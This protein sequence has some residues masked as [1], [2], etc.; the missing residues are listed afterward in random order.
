[1]AGSTCVSRFKPAFVYIVALKPA[2][3]A[4]NAPQLLRGVMGLFQS[5]SQMKPICP[6]Y[7]AG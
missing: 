7:I 3:G 6:E 5:Y 4:K 1:M 2:P